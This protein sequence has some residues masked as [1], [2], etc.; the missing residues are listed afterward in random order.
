MLT[1][2]VG[3]GVPVQYSIYLFLINLVAFYCFLC[4]LVLIQIFPEMSN[5][6][7]IPITVR[8]LEA[9][10]RISESLAKMELLPFASEQHIDEALRLFRVSTIEAAATGS[11]IGKFW[12]NFKCQG[13]ISLVKLGNI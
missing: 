4:I 9:I 5:R 10:I 6:S 12:R 1:I 13:K 8:Q 3:C 11:L 2:N 7:A